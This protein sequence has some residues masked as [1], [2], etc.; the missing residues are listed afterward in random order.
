[1][2][3]YIYIYTHTYMCIDMYTHTH[4]GSHSKNEGMPS[5][6]SHV[7]LFSPSSPQNMSKRNISTSICLTRQNISQTFEFY[8]CCHDEGFG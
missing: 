1:M 8:K 2:Y 4:S 6:V 3:I 5:F 7:P